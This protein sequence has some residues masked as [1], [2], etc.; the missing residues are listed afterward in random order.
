MNGQVIKA[1]SGTFTVATK[2]GVFDAQARKKLR[3]DALLVGDFVEFNCAERVIERVVPRKNALIRPPVANVDLVAAVIAP[4]PQPDLLLL[5]KIIITCIASKIPVLICVNKIDTADVAFLH[6]VRAEYGFFDIAE[7]SA[8]SRDVAGLTDA[9]VENG[10]LMVLAGQSACG[11]SSLI[12]ALLGQNLKTDGLSKKIKRGKN[13]T[14]EVRILQGSGFQI[15]DTC[16]FSA[17]GLLLVN[18]LELRKLY[19]DFAAYETHCRY[20]GCT[21][22]KEEECGVKL[23]HEA[24]KLQG[25]YPRY[26]QLFEEARGNWTGAPRKRDGL[27]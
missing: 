24:G 25:R 17:Y 20:G 16:G 15:A 5:D 11:K 13:T 23:A 26:L 12:N 1:V 27:I 22:T 8:A 4:E 10:G 21:H 18:P 9:F 19:P 7:V 14:R 3:K 6:R 2:D